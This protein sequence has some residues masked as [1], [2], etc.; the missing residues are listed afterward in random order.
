MVNINRV[1]SADDAI[2]QEPFGF[3]FV[4]DSPTASGCFIHHGKWA[5][6]AAKAPPEFWQHLL[7][8]GIH[9]FYPITSLP[10]SAAG[11]IGELAVPSQLAAFQALIRRLRRLVE[12]TGGNGHGA[13][14]D[15]E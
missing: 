9:A 10:A 8:S 14:G 13:H 12:E 6:R 11:P 2:D 5:G 7:A 15:G 1:D 3:A 4:G